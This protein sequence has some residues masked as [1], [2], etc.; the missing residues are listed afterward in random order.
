MAE[1]QESSSG[2][3]LHCVV[4]TPE[5]TSIDTQARFI[6]V[7]LFDGE[8]GIAPGRAP[9]IGRLGYG[10]LRVVDGGHTRRYYLDGGF[11]QVARN[12]VTILT[13]RAVP[14]EKL[15]AEVAAEQLRTARDRKANS[16]ESLAIRDRLVSQARAQLRMAGQR[17]PSGH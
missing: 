4:V 5:E 13:G 17:K 11:V 14:T 6:A 15:D 2:G 1:H 3:S 7:P 16:E 9:L 10:E 12:E 8:L